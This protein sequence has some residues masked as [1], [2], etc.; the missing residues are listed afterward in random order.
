LLALHL[1]RCQTGL[2]DAFGAAAAFDFLLPAFVLIGDLDLV[3]VDQAG[4]QQL[5]LQ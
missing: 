3:L 5:F 4:F 2:V 1:L